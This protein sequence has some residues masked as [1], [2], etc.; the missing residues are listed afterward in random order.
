MAMFEGA[1]LGVGFISPWNFAWSD[2]SKV[3]NFTILVMK[4]ICL[5][6]KM[7]PGNVTVDDFTPFSHEL[8]IMDLSKNIAVKNFF[9]SFKLLR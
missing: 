5:L 6:E 2:D 8:D 4:V 1:S 7:F 3:G 9:M